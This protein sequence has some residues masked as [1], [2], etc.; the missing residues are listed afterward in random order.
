MAQRHATY[1]NSN[2][3]HQIPCEK[4]FPTV[5]GLPIFADPRVWL[6]NTL[7]SGNSFCYHYCIYM[8]M[9]T[10]FRK[11]ELLIFTIF[12]FTVKLLNHENDFYQLLHRLPLYIGIIYNLK[13][14]CLHEKNIRLQRGGRNQPVCAWVLMTWDDVVVRVI[15]GHWSPFLVGNLFLKWVGWFGLIWWIISI[16]SGL[17]A[18]TGFLLCGTVWKSKL[19]HIVLKSE[20]AVFAGC[21][22]H[23]QFVISHIFFWKFICSFLSNSKKIP[24]KLPENHGN[25]K[26]IVP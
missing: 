24:K 22:K 26:S 16:L 23:T 14:Y 4:S 13:I 9:H 10:E 12:N 17:E 6:L 5:Y 21:I 3:F 1:E 2:R 15:Y 11:W 8:Y 25:R 7:N 18:G 19:I 20:L